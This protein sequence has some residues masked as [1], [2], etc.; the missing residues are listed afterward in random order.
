MYAESTSV[1]A[2]RSRAQIE[3]LLVKYGA[4]HYVSGFVEG[5]AFVAFR[6][7]GRFVKFKLPLPRRDEKRF[8]QDPKR[9]WRA[10]PAA[11]QVTLWEQATRSAWRSLLLCIKAKLESVNSNIESFEQAFLAHIVLPDGS[12]VGELALKAIAA[13]Y[14]NGKMPALAAM[15]E[16]QTEES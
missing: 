6:A 10:I 8:T 15:S 12:V 5:E 13:A 1:P 11:R 14:E 2:E 16:S 4:D 9:Y 3:Q 7:R